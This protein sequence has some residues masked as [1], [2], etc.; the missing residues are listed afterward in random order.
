MSRSLFLPLL[1]A[2]IGPAQTR[3]TVP[4][5]KDN[6]LYQDPSGSLSNGAGQHVFA[7]TNAAGLA[8]RGLLTFDLRGLLPPFATLHSA[9]ITLSVSQAQSTP[10][11]PVSLHRVSAPW[12][13]GDSRASGDEA[14]GASAT[15]GDATWRH[16]SFPTVQWTTAGGD[17]EVLPVATTT[18]V[19]GNGSYGFTSAQLVADVQYLAWHPEA[20]FGWL[21][22]GDE[23]GT[24]SAKRFASRE[25]PDPALRP[26]L[27]LTWTN[28]EPAI[29]LFGGLCG[30]FDVVPSGMCHIG[31]AAF[32]ADFV[33]G[34]PSGLGLL[35]V[36]SA[37]AQPW[38]P[39][40]PDCHVYLDPVAIA[41][42]TLVPLSPVGT[43]RVPLPIP[44]S[45]ALMGTWAYVQMVALD[46]ATPAVRGSRGMAL[47]L[48]D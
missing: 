14:D 21:I 4:A 31:N 32:A 38:L 37:E 22:Q 9:V 15:A 18:L 41:L 17:F 42:I 11:V 44:A 1:L 39:L 19:G 23:N 6:T 8:R 7:G 16:R 34:I 12:G 46:R 20:A 5:A 35:L 45:P 48:A 3:L 2:T 30:G 27:T 33:G 13:E 24:G 43:A 47:F 25:H 28:P 10:S 26:R 36:G 29:G 40:G